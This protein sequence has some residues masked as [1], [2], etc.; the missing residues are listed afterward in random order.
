MI[1]SRREFFLQTLHRVL[2]VGRFP[3]LENFYFQRL[4]FQPVLKF[5]KNHG[6][7]IAKSGTCEYIG[8]M[9][10]TPEHTE[11]LEGTVERVV[12]HN[13][14]SGWTVIRLKTLHPGPL[15]TVVGKFQR[16][17]AGETCRFS[18]SFQM[19]KMHGRQFKAETS[20]PIAPS[21][22]KGIERY[23]GSGLVPGLGPVMAKRIVDKFGVDTL[24]VLK[25]HPKRLSE[26]EGI[27]PKRA[28]AITEALLSKQALHE[29]MVFLE[30]VEISPAYALRIYKRFGND[31]IRIV[32][33][34][35]YRLASEVSGIGFVSADKIAM[36]LGIPK[37][38]APRIEAGI[39]YSLAELAKEGHVFAPPALLFE[40][41]SNLLGVDED[42]V[43]AAPPRLQL[44]G[45][46]RLELEDPEGCYLSSLFE[47]E[48]SA[49]DIL[50]RFIAE[51]RKPLEFDE[52][53]EIAALESSIG[54]HLAN[55]Q[56]AAFYALKRAKVL[57]LT[58]GP[59]T[60]KTTILRGLVGCLQTLRLRTAMAAPTGRAARR[61]AE[62]TGREASTLHRLLEFTP[63]TMRFER[64]EENPIEA[65]A[66]VV[67]EMSMVDIE[68]FAALL[69]AMPKDC[70]L[71]LV[72]DPNQ[73]PS[74]GPGTVLADLIALSRLHK[75]S[76]AAVHLDEIFR[77]A[78]SS[79][80]IT[81]AHDIL[82]GI[83]PKS[84]EKGESADMFLID[85][86]TPEE[87][88]DTIKSLVSERI[89]SSFGFDPIEDIQ[90]L[91]PM[92]KGLLGASNLNIELQELLNPNQSSERFRMGDK[93]MQIRNNYDLE[94]FNGD[95]GLVS[96]KDEELEWIE[97]SFYDRKVRYPSTE[98][99]Q[100]TLAYA[101]SIHKSQGS[102]YKAVI[103]PLHTQHFVMLKRN[104]LYTA[105]TRG[106]K[107]V[108]IV[109]TK[110]A[111]DIA[112]RNDDQLARHSGLVA[113]VE[114][115]IV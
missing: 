47:A 94:V 106:K 95:I 105:V 4:F 33:D 2:S 97:V 115:T 113:R 100:L 82:K 46:I 79:Y 58:G 62:T 103:I 21:T 23:L 86:E 8:R 37:D 16:L 41:A 10:E 57:L 76:F 87:C 73:L 19:D 18:G 91:T 12:F 45:K 66:V 36:Q 77:Q 102:E 27:G 35:P 39:L 65:D 25:N 110:R 108:V 84:G 50:A 42:L 96:A 22:V 61:M 60:G 28:T 52:E 89:P 5:P 14:M 53:K 104:L 80:I 51:R 63:K 3:A 20:V 92:H 44:M 59:G 48:K 40:Y 107:L 114:R 90:V 78:R 75:N 85:R 32:N 93:V 70:L 11:M 24:E 38:A 26:V 71:L 49:A 31:A 112:V 69:K 81:G 13:P 98:L 1:R 64:N 72:G 109:G 111:L 88:L 9:S 68:L 6:L 56:R 7:V 55:K 74:V 83:R 43:K 101:C 15:L 99:D 17:A 30:S 34:N 67:D 29:V 54:I